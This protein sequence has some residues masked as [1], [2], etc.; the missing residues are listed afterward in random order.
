M[1]DIFQRLKLYLLSGQV[2]LA[3]Q[4]IGQGMYKP[5]WWGGGLLHSIIYYRNIV[6]VH[7]EHNVSLKFTV[8][9]FIIAIKFLFYAVLMLV[10]VKVIVYFISQSL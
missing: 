1:V 10:Q 7:I 4:A 3:N 9:I 5:E 6:V 2:A 8:L